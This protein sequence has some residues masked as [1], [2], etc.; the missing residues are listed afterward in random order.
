MWENPLFCKK[1]GF[2][3][4]LS[5]KKLLNGWRCPAAMGRARGRG[6]GRACPARKGCENR[7]PEKAIGNP[8]F[9]VLRARRL[10]MSGHRDVSKALALKM[11]AGGRLNRVSNVG[12]SRVR[13]G[14]PACRFLALGPASCRSF[15][16]P[17]AAGLW[18]LSQKSEKGQNRAM[19]TMIFLVPRLRLGTHI[20]RALPGNCLAF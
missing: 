9:V 2:S 7:G 5:G 12:Q 14:I 10:R 13:R 16:F 1:A 11:I 4:T 18:R 15:L 17:V 19:K 3:H 20:F 6:R 8:L